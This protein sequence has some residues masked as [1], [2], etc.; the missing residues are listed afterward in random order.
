MIDFL[1][2]VALTYYLVLLLVYQDGPYDILSAFRFVMGVNV[3]LTDMNGNVV[4]YE[5]NGSQLAKLVTCHVCSSFWI[6]IL[7]GF[8]FGFPPLHYAGLIG[9]SVLFH[10][11]SS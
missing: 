1:S 5:S 11:L 10:Q 6:G 2:A 7:V 4:G 8:S 3:E 9:F